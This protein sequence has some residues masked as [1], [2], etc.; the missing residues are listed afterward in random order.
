MKGIP[1]KRLLIAVAILALPSFAQTLTCD[2]RYG[3]TVLGTSQ[4]QYW[5][6][7]VNPGLQPIDLVIEGDAWHG[8]L[9]SRQP[10][11][12]ATTF[13]YLVTVLNHNVIAINVP[14]Y[15]SGAAVIWPAPAQGARAALGYIAH[16]AN[17]ATQSPGTDSGTGCTLYGDPNNI[18]AYAQSSGTL[19]AEWMIGAPKSQFAQKCTYCDTSYT[20]TAFFAAAFIGDLQECADYSAGAHTAIRNM[21]GC[22][23]DVCT[24]TARAASWVDNILRFRK[25]Q[26]ARDNLT[27]R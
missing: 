18:R 10:N 7:P 5:Q 27:K 21:L 9:T 16:W 22:D 4:M 11:K 13:D 12:E 24:S 23:P 6:A 14:G 3:E 15:A 8:F 19:E 26:S 17:S 1:M 25:S 20:I 2:I